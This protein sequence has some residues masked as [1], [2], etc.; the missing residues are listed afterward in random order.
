MCVMYACMWNVFKCCC[1]QSPF[2]LLVL[3]CA[4]SHGST[5]TPKHVQSPTFPPPHPHNHHHHHKH[6]HKLSYPPPTW[7]P[8]ALP[9][10]GGFTAPKDKLNTISSA[11]CYHDKI[12]SVFAVCTTWRTSHTEVIA[13]LFHSWIAAMHTILFGGR[14]HI[15][16]ASRAIFLH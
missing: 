6:K 14:I 8:S 15:L 7:P 1:S 10:R 9:A 3:L 11:F 5:P 12:D 13:F 2:T 4:L 16:L